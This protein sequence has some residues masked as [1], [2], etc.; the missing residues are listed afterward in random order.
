MCA[1]AA[2]KESQ[3]EAG[4]RQGA[5]EESAFGTETAWIA[6]LPAF[7]ECKGHVHPW[8]LN[9][10]TAARIHLAVT[11]LRLACLPKRGARWKL[12]TTFVS[13]NASK[14]NLGIRRR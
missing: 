8:P 10:P 4:A 1:P 9:P 12:P 2:R 11:Q 14:Y 6:R 7:H 3:G 13:T 5:G